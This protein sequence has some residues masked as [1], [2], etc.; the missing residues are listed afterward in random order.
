MSFTQCQ[1]KEEIEEQSEQ[2]NLTTVYP[3]IG[4]TTISGYIK[5]ESGNTK[6]KVSEVTYDG[7]KYLM[8]VPTGSSGIR[9]QVVMV[10]K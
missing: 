6:W 10:K 4:N 9:Y 8:L 1:G 7:A 3:K 5:D 2:K